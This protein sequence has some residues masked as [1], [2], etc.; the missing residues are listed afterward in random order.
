M[1]RLRSYTGGSTLKK[2]DIVEDNTIKAFLDKCG[3][4]ENFRLAVKAR[5]KT[6]QSAVINAMQEE[7]LRV[8]EKDMVQ[9]NS[10]DCP[11]EPSL[12]R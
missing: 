4:S 9:S 2:A 8:G 5:P 11:R 7:C 1:K 6:L 12:S 3:Q 10:R